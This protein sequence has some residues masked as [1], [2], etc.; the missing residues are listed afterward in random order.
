MGNMA[1]CLEQPE[2]MFNSEVFS[3]RVQVIKEGYD[4]TPQGLQRDN[5]AF[6]EFFQHCTINYYDALVE[7]ILRQS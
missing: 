1:G 2:T 3:K 4:R 6:F 7:N 5:G